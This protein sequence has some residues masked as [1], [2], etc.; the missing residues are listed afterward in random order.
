MRRKKAACKSGPSKPP[1]AHEAGKISR[2]GGKR[3][4]APTKDVKYDEEELLSFVAIRQSN[5]EISKRERITLKTVVLG[6]IRRSRTA[7][8]LRRNCLYGPGRMDMPPFR[9][10]NPS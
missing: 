8:C 10:Q 9:R 2:H 7:M 3:P 6:A 4:A 1:S 5:S